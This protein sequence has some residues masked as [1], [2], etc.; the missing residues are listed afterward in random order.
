MRRLLMIA[1]SQAFSTVQFFRSCPRE[2]PQQADC[3]RSYPDLS[4][5]FRKTERVSSVGTGR[6]DTIHWIVPSSKTLAN[7]ECELVHACI[8][9]QV[10]KVTCVIKM[11]FRYCSNHWDVENCTYQL[12]PVD[13]SLEGQYA[14]KQQRSRVWTGLLFSML[15]YLLWLSLSSMACEPG[16][17]KKDTSSK[18]QETECYD[19]K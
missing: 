16:V 12:N 9:S 7:R 13:S 11:I 18:D 3:H 15:Y 14:T 17:L 19:D 10:N 2:S 5:S 8:S 6:D 1:W 4:L